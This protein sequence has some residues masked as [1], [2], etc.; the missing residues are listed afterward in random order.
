LVKRG[1]TSSK[2]KR[3]L[4]AGNGVNQGREKKSKVDNGKKKGECTRD[5]EE[6]QIRNKN[7]LG[8]NGNKRGKETAK[9]PGGL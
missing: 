3:G 5:S 6:R 2:K 4:G 7:E 8:T 9:C 1:V